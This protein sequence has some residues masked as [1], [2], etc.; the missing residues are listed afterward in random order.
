[1]IRSGLLFLSLFLSFLSLTAQD[2]WSVGSYPD[3]A[4]YQ[5]RIGPMMQKIAALPFGEKSK[6]FSHCPDTGLPVRSWAVEG[7]TIIS[8]YT[9]SKYVQGPTGYFGPKERNATGKII[10]FG[11]DPLK[12]E[13]PPATAHLLLNPQDEKAKAF[14]SIQGNLN[15]Q[16][17]FAAKNWARFYPMLA[18]QMGTDWQANFQ[19]AVAD[20]GEKRRPSDGPERQYAPLSVN[21]D[22]VGEKGE[23]LG[24]NKQDGGTENHKTMWRTSGLLYAQLFPKNSLIS[25]YSTEKTE[26]QISFFLK[27]YLK[28]MLTM[29]NGEYD[30]QIYYPHSIEA[31]L[32]L[33]DFSPDPETRT[34][35]KLTL[36]YYLAT[37]GLKVYDGAIAGAQKRGNHAVNYAGEM[38]KHL[39]AWFGTSH[40]EDNPEKLY[41]SIHQVTS[42]YRPNA[43]IYKLVHKN[44][45]LP[46]EAEI[47]RPFY[48]MDVENQFQEYFY[49]SKNF[50]IGS[51]YMTRVDNPNQQ[52]VWSLVVKGKEGPMTFGG[53]QPYHRAPGGHSPYTQTMQKEN[54]ILVASAPT[55][56][57]EGSKSEEQRI[58]QESFATETLRMLPQPQSENLGQFFRE[59]RF[60]AA[61]WLFVPRQVDDILERHGRI[62]IDAGSAYLF[63][64]PTTPDYYW[65]DA[66]TDEVNLAV[67]IDK[68]AALLHNNKVLVVPGEFSGYALEAIEKNSY[69]SLE[70]FA[71]KVLEKSKFS[72]DGQTQKIQYAAASGPVLEMEYQ[73]EGLRCRGT[74]NGEALNFEQWADGKAYRSPNL[75][76]GQEQMTISDGKQAYTIDFR[77]KQPKI[78]ENPDP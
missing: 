36:D 72:G 70:D 52:V 22:L 28:R 6:A 21:H 17:H 64:S 65:L 1:M 9:G 30:S 61:T 19:R 50:G 27:D 46:F 67:N 16:Y 26:A 78:I 7:D 56:F 57:T 76:S 62:F 41:S 13:L 20:Y 37:Y 32:N 31:Y 33:Y 5:Q 59:A 71:K 15:Q 73:S 40:G 77:A 25:G 42:S 11:G 14:L 74:I 48:H 34:L 69:A 75:M 58:R 18:A 43:L 44:I 68:N 35:A 49:G 54:V 60:Q 12:R 4:G 10:K 63:I 23:L 2:I 3:E 24:G 8:P 45:S 29:S 66:D 39:Y 51:V 38:R 53:L 47:A 55:K